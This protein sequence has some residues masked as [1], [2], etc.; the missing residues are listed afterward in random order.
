MV[1]LRAASLLSSAEVS[2][3]SNN[4]ILAVL[5]LHTVKVLYLTIQPTKMKTKV[6][7]V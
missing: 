1:S 3:S 4:S 7:H 2:L 6:V 5:Y